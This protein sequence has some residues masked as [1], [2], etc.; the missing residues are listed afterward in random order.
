MNA[1]RLN[2]KKP[3]FN[4]LCHLIFEFYLNFEF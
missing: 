3:F 1:K 4:R 2:V